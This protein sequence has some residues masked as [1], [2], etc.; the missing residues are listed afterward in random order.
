MATALSNHALAFLKELHFAVLSTINKDGTSQLTNMWYL[1]DDDG[2]IVM[3]TQVHLQK[4]KNIRRDPRIAICVEDGPRYVSING[5]VDIIEDQ[6]IIR[7]DIECL[8]ERY[9][10]DEETRRQYI[11]TFVRQQRIALRLRC[12]KVVEFFA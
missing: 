12:E 7:H 2:T 4:A 3:N 8:V 10:K 9:I 5:T 6:E 1:L 11:T